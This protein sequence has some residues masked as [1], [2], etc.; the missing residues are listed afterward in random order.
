MNNKLQNANDNIIRGFKDIERNIEEEPGQ[1]IRNNM[2]KD[3]S[4]SMLGF[5]EMKLNKE[6]EY[7][8]ISHKDY[9]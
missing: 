3:F 8:K 2:L 7:S 1:E 5:L 4:Q 6:S 9:V